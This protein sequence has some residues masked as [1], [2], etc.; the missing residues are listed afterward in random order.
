[1]R[2]QNTVLGYLLKALP[3]RRLGLSR[4]LLKFARQ[5]LPS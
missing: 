3:R 2:Y 1:V 4:F 5:A